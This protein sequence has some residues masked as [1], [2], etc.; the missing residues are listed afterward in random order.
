MGQD[1]RRVEMAEAVRRAA[2]VFSAVLRDAAQ[3]GLTVR[4][5]VVDVTAHGDPA[6]SFIVVPTEITHNAETR[7]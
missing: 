6:P 1:A 2:D 3:A 4:L 5:D 7:Y